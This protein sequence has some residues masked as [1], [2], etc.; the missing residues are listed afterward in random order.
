MGSGLG[1][2]T[3]PEPTE[4]MAGGLVGKLAGK[5]KAA[6]GSLLAHA[7]LSREGRLQEAHAEA[8]IAAQRAAAEARV[9]ADH[10]LVQE[11]QAKLREERRRLEA[12]AR[13]GR[14]QR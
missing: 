13:R 5:A 4:D 14:L 1:M 6:A 2:T 8:D 7:D 10:A 9:A 12:D 11:E 3:N